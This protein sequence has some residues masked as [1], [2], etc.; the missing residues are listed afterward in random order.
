MFGF[1]FCLIPHL[2][3][4][5]VDGAGERALEVLKEAEERFGSQTELDF[6]RLYFLF[7]YSNG[8]PF[9]DKCKE[10]ALNGDSLVPYLFTSSGKATI[11]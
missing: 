10:L 8:E 6:W 7:I 4:K 11:N 3:D 2:S 1:R 9:E 5:F